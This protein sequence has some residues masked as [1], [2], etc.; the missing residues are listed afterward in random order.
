[1]VEMHKKLINMILLDGSAEGIKTLHLSGNTFFC[2]VFPRPLFEQFKSL[3]EYGKPGVY[4]IVGKDDDG[5]KNKIYIGEGDPVGDRLYSHNSKKDFWTEA[6]VMTSIDKSL[7]KTRIQ[8][9]ESKLITLGFNCKKVIM[10]NSNSPGL[11]SVTE[12]DE[13]VVSG[14]LN[15]ALLVI[16]AMGYNFFDPVI[17]IDE[18]K[19]ADVI[20]ELKASKHKAYGKMVVKQGKYVLLK[21]SLFAKTLT[22]GARSWVK[23][24]RKYLM[25]NNLLIEYDD[26]TLELIDNTEFDSPSGAGSVV[27]GYNVN[28]F[29]VW[30]N[31]GKTLAEYEQERNA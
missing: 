11:P 8:Y 6:I 25:D 27:V 12:S 5:I 19:N 22:D 29:Q 10:D 28:G 18:T 4:I 20:F 14:F 16:K 31:N 24:N 7:S 3:Q 9:I 17:D 15:S 30:K 13:I 23:N 1:M 26:E 21:G 2:V